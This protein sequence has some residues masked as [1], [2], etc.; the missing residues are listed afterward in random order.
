MASSNYCYECIHYYGDA[1]CRAYKSIPVRFMEGVEE[2]DEI[3]TD[4]NGEYVFLDKS[5]SLDDFF[6]E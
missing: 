2:H 3:Q 5:A 6:R 1:A 4:Q